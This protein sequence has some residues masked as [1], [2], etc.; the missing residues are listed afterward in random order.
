MHPARLGGPPQDQSGSATLWTVED[1]KSR[2]DTPR[3]SV[4]VPQPMPSAASTLVSP[5]S[6]VP[7]LSLHPE[8][9]A[10]CSLQ[11]SMNTCMHA[12]L[13]VSAGQ[14]WGMAACKS[15]LLRD[16][17]GGLEMR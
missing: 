10:T 7:H 5:L 17:E 15:V 11:C 9:A 13:S 8:H 6:G 16:R 1:G 14:V 12:C 3:T 2:V 4:Y